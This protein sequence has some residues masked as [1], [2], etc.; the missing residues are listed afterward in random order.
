MA[1][2]GTLSSGTTAMNKKKVDEMVP[3][4]TLG[5]NLK[6]LW[7]KFIKVG[8]A[9]KSTI[10]K[11]EYNSMIRVEEFKAELKGKTFINEIC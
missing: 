9:T 10:E 11:F 4:F 5:K 7:T 8:N 1:P 3:D 6:S 2:P